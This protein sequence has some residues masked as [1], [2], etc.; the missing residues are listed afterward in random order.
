LASEFAQ[1]L[2]MIAL[3]LGILAGSYWF[4]YAPTRRSERQQQEQQEGQR[5]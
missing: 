1:F 5:D 3:L 4:V 2:G